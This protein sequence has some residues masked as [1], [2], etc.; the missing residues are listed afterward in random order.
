[1]PFLVSGASGC[2]RPAT[3]DKYGD[4]D[5]RQ[6]STDQILGPHRDIDYHDCRGRNR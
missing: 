3:K 4:V 6:R 5:E 1:M 2:N